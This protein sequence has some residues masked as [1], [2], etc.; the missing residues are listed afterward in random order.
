M[1]SELDELEEVAVTGVDRNPG[2]VKRVKRAPGHFATGTLLPRIQGLLNPGLFRERGDTNRLVE[3]V[4]GED[5]ALSRLAATNPD[6]A[7]EIRQ[8]ANTPMSSAEHEK[9]RSSLLGMVSSEVERNQKTQYQLRDNQGFFEAFKMLDGFLPGSGNDEIDTREEY[10]RRAI[11]TL[12]KQAQ[13]VALIDPDHSAALMGEVRKKADALTDNVRTALDKRRRV[14]EAEDSALWSTAR[15]KLSET[16]DVV[17]ALQDDLDKKGLRRDPNDA[18]M[19]RALALLGRAGDFPSAGVEDA[20]SDATALIPAKAG[21]AGNIAGEVIKLAS[22]ATDKVLQADDVRYLIQR[23]QFNA[24][25]VQASYIQDRA[26]LADKYKAS[27]LKFGEKPGEIYAVP[28]ELYQREADKIKAAPKKAT[29]D[30]DSL[31]GMLTDEE[32]SAQAAVDKVKPEASANVPGASRRL[33]AA[34]ERL[35]LAKDDRAIFEDDQR[36]AAATAGG[37][38]AEIVQADDASEEIK[39]ARQRRAL[40]Q[41]QQSATQTHQATM[42][43]LRGYTR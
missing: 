22:K 13:E 1:A 34:L 28:N 8:Q 12:Y 43:A 9:F 31:R 15:E 29:D 17:A 6:L 25:Q 10:E 7:T 41:Q 42:K 40:R 18:L 24:Q 11:E 2:A 4:L 38:A 20:A 14:A 36:Q 37:R 16:S 26:A 23:L 35:Q 30:V 19:A 21:E 32:E 5:G 27:G 39:K 3:S 33:T